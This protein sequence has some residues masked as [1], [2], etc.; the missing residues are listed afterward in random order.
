MKT[1][2]V[3]LHGELDMR[4]EEFELP[5][6]QENEILMRVITDSLCASTYKA[7]KQGVNHKR[8][9]D[10]IAE[11][12]VII[13]HELCGEIVKV[14]AALTGEWKEGQKAVVQPALKTPDGH[15]P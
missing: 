13:G 6:I 14:G 11:N 7:V 5:E 15:D 10:D 9:P 8:V 12:P 4:V 1:K 3:R 2:A